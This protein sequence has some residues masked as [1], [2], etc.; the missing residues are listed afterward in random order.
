[1]TVLTKNSHPKS[2]TR[3][4][5]KYSR[6]T[7]LV[8]TFDVST[9]ATWAVI[10]SRITIHVPWITSGKSGFP[11]CSGY[12]FQIAAPEGFSA[13]RSAPARTTPGVA[14]REP[15]LLVSIMAFIEQIS[16]NYAINCRIGQLKVSRRRKSDSINTTPYL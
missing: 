4:E 14:V 10:P 16:R 5:F 13:C 7:T 1:M 9:S 8:P 2:G 6:G 15:D 12:R 11:N 3:V